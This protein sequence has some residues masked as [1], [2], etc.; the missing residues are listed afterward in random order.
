MVITLKSIG[1]VLSPFKNKQDIK[2]G[3]F[4]TRMDFNRIEGTPILD[5]KPYTPRDR[6]KEIETGWLT[7]KIK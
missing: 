4:A 2:T 3:K 7:D 1:Q 5:I 6:K